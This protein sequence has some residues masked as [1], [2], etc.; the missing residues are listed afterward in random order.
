M[1]YQA[2]R[3]RSRP[4]P[5]PESL[6]A[7]AYLQDYAALLDA[8]PFPSVVLDHRWDVVLSNAGFETLFRGVGPHPTAMPG[9]NF[10][11]FVLF[12][13]DASMILGEHESSWC[14]PMLAHFAAA[15]ERHGQDRGLQAIR[16]DIA[17]DPIMEAAYRHGLPH[18]IR[19]VGQE[20]LEHDGAV[21]PLVHPDPRWGSTDCRIVGE[22]PKSLQDMGYTRMTLVLREARHAATGPRKARKTRNG[23]A[24][25]RAV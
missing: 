22:T 24:E 1:A 7:Q 23:A 4:R 17:Q 13:P 12:H 25:L 11:R 15:V 19:A 21:R 10:L 8:V 9:D 6:E 18:W 2:G 20:A 16:R 5:V 14:L 3:Q